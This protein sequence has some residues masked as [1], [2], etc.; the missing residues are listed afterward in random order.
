MSAE[1]L[2]DTIGSLTLEKT[3]SQPEPA[4]ECL[5]F[6]PSDR[7]RYLA[8]SLSPIPRY[9][10][11]VYTPLSDGHTD[12]SWAMSRD[13]WAQNP[14]AVFDLFSRDTQVA[15]LMLDGHL[16]WTDN[17]TRTDNFVS[18]TSSLLF[19]LQY[20]FYRH[21]S[22]RDGSMLED[23]KLCIIDTTAFADGTFIRDMDL[24]DA[25]EQFNS[26]LA[27]L[28]K[29]RTQEYYFGEY[30][31]Q[32]ALKIEAKSK[33]V[34]ARAIVD[35]GLFLLQP[36]FAA[37]MTAPNCLWAKEVLRLREPFRQHGSKQ[38]VTDKQARAGTRIAQLFGWPWTL[39]VAAN[40]LAIVP[41][42]DDDK[43]MLNAFMNGVVTGMRRTH[44]EEFLS[45]TS[46]QN[47]R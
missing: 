11:R 44:H 27:S 31:S 15:A 42:H 45:L 28:R 19:A 39:A 46:T 5:P 10:F 41:R 36:S 3:I 17:S 18:W 33:V 1:D 14:T 23:I 38:P 32:G 7:F 13:A 24:I 6:Q 25:Y 30:L 16:R 9:L 37:T 2:I 47:M 12:D 35:A 8:D 21:K 29:L 26:G 43:T 20:I 22:A 34:S 4:E 40:F